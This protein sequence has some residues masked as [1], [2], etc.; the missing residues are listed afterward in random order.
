LILYAY[1]S[2]IG[3]SAYNAFFFAY[4]LY[5]FFISIMFWPARNESS[6]KEEERERA[7]LA[8]SEESEFKGF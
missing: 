2:R 3:G 8:M 1:G 7:I 6:E 4:N 5:T